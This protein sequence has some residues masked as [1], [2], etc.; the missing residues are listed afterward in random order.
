M[1]TFTGMDIGAVRQ[2]ASQL[3]AKA[4]EIEQIYNQLTAALDHVQWVGSDADRFRGDWHG[5]H[6]NQLHQ[7]AVALRDASHLATSNANQQ[8]EASSH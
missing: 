3:T 8:E 5:Q 4:D 6:R 1:S 2:L 7:V